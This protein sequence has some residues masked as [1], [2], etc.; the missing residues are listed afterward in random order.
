MRFLDFVGDDDLE[1]VGDVL[2]TWA[3]PLEEICAGPNKDIIR[4]L[5]EKENFYIDPGNHDPK[6]E[7]LWN[8]FPKCREITYLSENYGYNKLHGHTLD[9]ELDN[10]MKMLFA[11]LGDR[12]ASESGIPAIEMIRDYIM[13]ADNNNQPLIAK[14]EG[15]GKFIVGHT[16]IALDLGW[17]LN[18]GFWFGDKCTYL[19][20]YED[21]SH[22]MEVFDE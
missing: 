9:P 16:H 4:R 12:L 18:L 6:P 21:G 8:L 17:Y 19:I 22:E 13:K 11:Q 2:D 14:L 10:R 20:L 7:I 1:C 15:Q 5:Q 3:W